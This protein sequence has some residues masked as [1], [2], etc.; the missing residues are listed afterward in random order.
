MEM[1]KT[2]SQCWKISGFLSSLLI[3]YLS[4]E[5]LG[6]MSFIFLGFMVQA[7]EMQKKVSV[8]KCVNLVGS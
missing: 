7:F 6:F 3:K 8:R 1:K 4:F 2:W 5:E